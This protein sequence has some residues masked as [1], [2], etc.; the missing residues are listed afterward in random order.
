MH[1][2]YDVGDMKTSRK[3]RKIG[4]QIESA[5]GV[6]PTDSSVLRTIGWFSAG[7]T[8]LAVGLVVGREIRARYRFTRR[9]PYDAYSHAGD[10][11]QQDVEFGLGV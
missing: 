4:R 6:N 10:Q 9:T 7:V 3:F 5:T 1:L 11:Q 2:R 8:A